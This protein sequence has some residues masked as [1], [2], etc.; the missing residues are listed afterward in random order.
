M[1][2]TN[3]S[4]VNLAVVRVLVWMRSLLRHSWLLCL[5]AELRTELRLHHRLTSFQRTFVMKRLLATVA[6]VY[7]SNGI[8]TRLPRLL[9]CVNLILNIF[10]DIASGQIDSLMWNLLL[11]WLR[12]SGVSSAYRERG[13][14]L[15]RGAL[16]LKFV[17]RSPERGVRKLALVWAA[18]FLDCV[19]KFFVV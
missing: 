8:S 10:Y 5:F 3:Q 4:H 19:S 12:N 6:C 11:H 7:L 16:P 14:R 13:E 1:T 9:W 18:T 17:I 2:C 15:W